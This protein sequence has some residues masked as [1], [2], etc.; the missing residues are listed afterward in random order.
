MRVE[1]I[2]TGSE[3]TLGFTINL[4][5]S[6]IAGQLASIGLRLD[7]QVTVADDRAEMRG[8]V[9]EAL[10]RSDVLIIASEQ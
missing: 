9:G 1:L 5:L 8:A 6:Y 10:R 7:R 3:L 4:H 2:N